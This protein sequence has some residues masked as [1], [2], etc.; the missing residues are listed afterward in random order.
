MSTV[1]SETLLV[2]RLVLENALTGVPHMLRVLYAQ[3]LTLPL[4]ACL[5]PVGS[6]WHGLLQP[7]LEPRIIFTWPYYAMPLHWHG[8]RQ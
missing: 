4:P 3:R 1:Y 5:C 7:R 2:A 6:M 8:S